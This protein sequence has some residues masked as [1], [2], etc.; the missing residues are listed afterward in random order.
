MKAVD[1]SSFNN[2]NKPEKVCK[3][4][5]NPPETDV[6][7]LRML[8]KRPY[9][10]LA[11]PKDLEWTRTMIEEATWSQERMNI[12]QPF[13]YLTVR[14]GIQMPVRDQ[15]EWHVDGFSTQITHL[16]E[17]NYIW[18]DNNPTE[19]ADQSFNVPMDFDPDLHNVNWLLQ[20]QV[21]DACI[22][23]VEVGAMYCFDPYVLHRR[24]TIEGPVHR[25]FIRVSFTPIEIADKNNTPNPDLPTYH[26]RDGVKDFRNRL[27][28]YVPKTGQLSV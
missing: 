3:F 8:V 14:H 16:P 21:L 22:K 10:D 25:T 2:Y 23:K 9:A 26:V 4:K 6:M 12:F 28:R 11:L 19:Y 24:A 15:E 17:Q 27:R 1:A 13:C 7:V 18:C 20:D 5:L